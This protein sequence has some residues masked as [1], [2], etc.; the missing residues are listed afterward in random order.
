MQQL[1]TIIM[2]CVAYIPGNSTTLID[3]LTLS[4]VMIPVRSGATNPG[5]LAIVFVI[6]IRK[7]E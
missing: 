1:L 2:N 7:P 3:K 6:D 5:I 4:S